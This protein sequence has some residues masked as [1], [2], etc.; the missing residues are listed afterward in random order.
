MSADQNLVGELMNIAKIGP[1]ARRAEILSHVTDLFVLRG[2]RLSEDEIALF[3][4]VIL[5]LTVEIE[6]RARALLSMRLAPIPHAPPR[7]I[8]KLAFDDEIEVAGPVLSQSE[9]LTEAA[10]IESAKLK[11]QDHMLAISRRRTLG[12]A[13]T[14]LLIERGDHQVLLSTTQNAG[15]KI[16]I[17]GFSRLASR[18]ETDEALTICV[19]ERQ[20]IPPHVFRQLIERASEIVRTK[21][22]A[23]HPRLSELIEETVAEVA[24]RIERK[25]RENPVLPTVNEGEPHKIDNI[26]DLKLRQVA[27]SG[28]LND[29]KLT[30]AKVCQM[31]VVFVEN[32]MQ[33]RRSEA[34]LLLT[35]A[36]GI[37][38]STVK[39]ILERRAE[40]GL[41]P[42]NEIAQCRLGF[43]RIEP[44]TAQHILSFYRMREDMANARHAPSPTKH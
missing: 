11:G 33:Q 21:L 16:S 37:S 27:Q 19:G 25:L 4:D 43:E 14:N 24:Q 1:S 36:H 41:I 34:L 29:L 12:E 31:P 32:A 3:D 18:S 13:V 42:Y 15:A 10:L 30:L 28:A 39:M 9:R 22:R 44:K 20:D 5:R 26:K 35:K 23:S 40:H 17:A 6:I 38:W 8:H 2:A 7:T